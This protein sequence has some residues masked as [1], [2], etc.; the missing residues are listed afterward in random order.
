MAELKSLK[1]QR[2]GHRGFVNIAVKKTQEVISREFSEF[3]DNKSKLRSY[4]DTLRQKLHTDALL[5]ITYG[6][7]EEEIVSVSEYESSV[8][9]YVLGIVLLANVAEDAAILFCSATAAK[10]AAIYILYK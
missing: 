5:L 6:L 4:Q 3:Y 9:V 1:S 2:A 10:D 8:N 7:V